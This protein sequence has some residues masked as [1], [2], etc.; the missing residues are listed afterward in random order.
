MWIISFGIVTGM[1]AALI[2]NG[3]EG[4]PFDWRG[5]AGGAVLAGVAFSLGYYG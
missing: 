2:V 5:I 3:P 4:M 1:V